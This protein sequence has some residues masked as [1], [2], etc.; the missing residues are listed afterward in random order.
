MTDL[1][2]EPER[3]RLGSSEVV[4]MDVTQSRWPRRVPRRERVSDMIVDGEERGKKNK[5]G[6]ARPLVFKVF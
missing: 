6:G 1:S 3:M 4:A 2:R 5:V